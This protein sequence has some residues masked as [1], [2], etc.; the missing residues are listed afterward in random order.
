[1]GNAPQIGVHLAT[2]NLFREGD[3]SVQLTVAD[4]RG[5]LAE[6]GALRDGKSLIGQVIGVAHSAAPIEFV[7]GLAVLAADNIRT[8]LGYAIPM[9]LHCPVCRTQHIDE[10]APGWTNPPHR[11]HKCG[12]CGCI[13]RPCDLP[14]V[15]VATVATKGQAD[16]YDPNEP[17]PG[18]DVMIVRDCAEPERV[19]RVPLVEGLEC[20]GCNKAPLGWRCTRGEGHEGPCAAVPR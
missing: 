2:L 14:T 5:A 6:L 10:P 7:E 4:A 13:W 11:S 15:G 1:M 3:G 17:W 8:R 19:E 9:V 20:A 12:S 18:Q 16:T